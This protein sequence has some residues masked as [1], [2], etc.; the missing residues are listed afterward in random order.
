M[1]A[2]SAVGWMLFVLSFGIYRNRY[3]YVGSI[4]DHPELYWAWAACIVGPVAYVLALIHAVMWKRASAAIGSV[5]ALLG[6]VYTATLGYALITCGIYTYEAVK[7]SDEEFS[8]YSAYPEY[9]GLM[10]A[11]SFLACLFWGLTVAL[12]P[13]YT[14]GTAK[15]SKTSDYLQ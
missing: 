11:G 8:E 3:M 15:V 12:W 13:W 5:T 1:I 10:L 9:V 7:H 2:M 6:M 4:T 14:D